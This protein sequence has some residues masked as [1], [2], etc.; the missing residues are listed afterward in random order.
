LPQGEITDLSQLPQS[1]PSY[2]IK[3]IPE[4]K[5]NGQTV[6]A[7]SAMRLG[8]D[9]PLVTAVSFAGRG[10]IQSPRTYNVTA[11]S[12]LSV[13]AIAGSVSPNELKQLKTR[14]EQT[15]TKLESNDQAQI[16]A[17]TRE[18]LL[19]DL[20]RAGTLGYYV[21]LIGLNH[22]M[23]LQTG[24][25]Y[26]LGAGTGTFGYEP[27]VSYFFGIPKAIEPGG[28]VFDIPLLTIAGV[29][30]GDPVKA[31]QFMQQ[32]GLLSSRRAGATVR[33]RAKSGG[34]HFR[35]QSPAKSQRRRATHLPHHAG[36]SIDYTGQYPP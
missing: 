35:R 3:V 14:L 6:K 13:N 30:D 12:Y 36:Q 4:L 22:L 8:E 29:N 23:G 1:I 11:G 32:S 27:K 2:L 26:Q 28:A 7:G 24:S 33:Q 15:K 25:H 21:Q 18:D 31:K 34:S 19:G 10:Q 17:L 9:L 16:A 5:L 20:F